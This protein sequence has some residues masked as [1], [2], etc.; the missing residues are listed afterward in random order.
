[1][2]SIIDYELDNIISDLNSYIYIKCKANISDFE[3][4]KFEN[5]VRFSHLES[6]LYLNL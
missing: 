3:A 4:L 5:P 1:M 6:Y 2:K